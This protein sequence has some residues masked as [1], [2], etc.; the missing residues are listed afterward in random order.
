MDDRT[1]VEPVRPAGAADLPV[2]D[3]PPPLLRRERRSTPSLR[4]VPTSPDTSWLT[5]AG[6]ANDKTGIGA[7]AN[8]DPM[9]AGKIV[10]DGTGRTSPTS[11]RRPCGVRRGGDGHVPG[12]VVI[13]EDSK[14]HR[15][16]II[17]A[18]QEKAVAAVL[19]SERP[20]G[21]QPG[22]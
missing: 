6:G 5:E 17:W 7:S 22:R 3:P 20:E 8:C 14:V 18:T 19:Q 15:V 21:Q 1:V 16:P 12:H 2:T 9:L 11:T 4:A 13:A 10:N